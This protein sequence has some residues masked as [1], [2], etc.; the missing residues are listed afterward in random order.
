MKAN[1]LILAALG[2]LM[3]VSCDKEPENTFTQPDAVDMG[4][5]VK[6]AS[7]NLGATSPE[8]YGDYYA[9]GETGTY[10]QDGGAQSGTP[11][12]KSGKDEGYVWTSYAWSDSNGW[13]MTKY[14]PEVDNKKDLEPEDDVVR[15]VLG[16]NWRM[17]SMSDWLALT[18][19][20]NCTWVWTGNGYNVTSNITHN[21][22]F[23]PAAGVRSGL[24]LDDSGVRGC[25]WSSSIN[26]CYPVDARYVVIT[27]DGYDM[28]EGERC[29]GVSVRPVTD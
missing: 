25:Y 7:C 15:S 18:N 9:W 22:I 16:G 19:E 6:W 12:W 23:L 4:L 11:D 5:G 21:S 17:P 1:I 20:D 14:N 28:D 2:G 8:E 3:A 10:Y 27:A 29:F 26:T 24:S 13:T